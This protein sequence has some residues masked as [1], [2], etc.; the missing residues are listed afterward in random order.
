MYTHWMWAPQ[1]R[2]RYPDVVLKPEKILIDEGDVICAG[3]M[4][5]YLDLCL[6]LVNKYG[7]SELASICSKLLLI[8]SGRR[9]QQPYQVYS[10]QKH[11]LDEEILQTQ[12]WLES[13]YMES[14]SVQ[15]LARTAGLEKRTFMRRF[16]S[17]TGDTPR[18][19]VQHL[20]LEAAKRMLE[21]SNKTFSEITWQV[22]YQDTSSF[23]WKG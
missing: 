7:S 14:V 23:Q 18:R 4:T 17:A 11:H 19:Y 1:F 15:T 6:Y 3:G 13:H 12:E 10:I 5:A 9:S 2:E 21:S 16:K 22:G 20:R 8:D